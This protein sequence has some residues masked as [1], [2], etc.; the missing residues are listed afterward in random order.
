M[1]QSSETTQ[2]RVAALELTRGR[3]ERLERRLQA[4]LI[5]AREA[6]AEALA[7]R[8]ERLGRTQA[9]R[10]QLRGLHARVAHMMT[11]GGAF[12]LAE[13]NATMRYAD[14]VAAR[15]Q[16]MESELASFETALRSQ[17]D[18]LAAATRALALNCGR[19]DVCNER[20]TELSRTL[21]RHVADRDDEE[22]EEAA[23]A[24]LRQS[25]HLVNFR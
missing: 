1:T 24:R 3:R 12:Q 6:H 14:V 17:A 2:R 18:E 16:Q 11:G 25:P 10:E 5:G 21:E 13:H 22:T 8:D 15:L 4:R 20:I 23:L 9:E 19:I 7:H